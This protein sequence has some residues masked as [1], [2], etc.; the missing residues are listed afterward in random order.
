MSCKKKRRANEKKKTR[1]KKEK[2]RKNYILIAAESIEFYGLL[3]TNEVRNELVIFDEKGTTAYG[4]VNL[5]TI[6]FLS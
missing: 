2:K 6:F 3:L 4:S 1:G 5:L